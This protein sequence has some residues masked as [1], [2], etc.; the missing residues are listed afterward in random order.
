M[1]VGDF[2]L[3]KGR[4]PEASLS[5]SSLS[6]T[7][8]SL[9]RAIPPLH[10][11]PALKEK[12]DL[13]SFAGATVS[14]PLL[15]SAASLDNSMCSSGGHRNLLVSVAKV[16]TTDLSFLSLGTAYDEAQSCSEILL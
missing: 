8:P 9:L 14:T 4:E 3:F 15:C 12:P 11:A 1:L 10:A 6:L 16:A 7:F 2:S 5:Q 13:S